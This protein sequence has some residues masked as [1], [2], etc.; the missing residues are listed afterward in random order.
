M[1]QIPE[2]PLGR[3][4]PELGL[5]LELGQILWVVLLE[6]VGSVLAKMALTPSMIPLM[7]R[8]SPLRVKIPSQMRRVPLWLGQALAGVRVGQLP[9]LVQLTLLEVAWV[10]AQEGVGQPPVLEV[11]QALAQVQV[12]VEEGVE[13]L[14][15]EVVEWVQ[16]LEVG[17]APAVVEQSSAG[18][19]IPAWVEQIPAGV[20][21]GH[22][23][24]EVEHI[25]LE[26][27]HILVGV[28]QIGAGVGQIAIEVGHT[29][30]WVGSTPH[31][32]IPCVVG[33]I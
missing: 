21:Q 1:D 20:G 29:P 17:W 2:A 16:L 25:P 18:G 11:E 32:P 6:E 12:E 33:Q 31:Q 3:A 5:G 23:A 8:G 13:E 19:H 7:K 26:V 28:E 10:L 30:V 24:V 4:L 27:G 22:T 9:S 15:P 14:P